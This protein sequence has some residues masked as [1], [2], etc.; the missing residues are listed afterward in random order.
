ML[1]ILEELPAGLLERDAN[2]VHEVLSGPTLIHLQGRRR[3]P[4]LV[5]VLL[6]GNEV[7]GWLAARELLRQ[8]AHKAL[9]RSLSLLIGNVTAARLATRRLDEQPDYNRVWG[10]G[11]TPEHAVARQVVAEM[12]E[13]RAFASVDVHNN[14]GFNPHYACVNRLAH[15][16]LHLATLYSRTVVYFTKPDTVQSLAMAQICPAVTLEC[17]QPGQPHG[18]EHVLE[19]LNACLH[20]TALPEHPV[21][22]HD[23]DLFHTVA[24]LKVPDH[25]SF[26]FRGDGTDI[27]FVSDLDHLNFR[28]LCAGTVLGWVRGDGQTSLEAWDEQGNEVGQRY[29]C[30]DEGRITT[31]IPIMPSMLTLD[32]RVIRQDCL[33]YIMERYPLPQSAAERDALEVR[34]AGSVSAE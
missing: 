31:A 32:I 27:C 12:A 4:L 20:L 29:F 2:Q 6:H 15:P 18:T 25:R 17:G 34:S 22:A 13:R 19:Y 28:E 1:T 24:V 16:F 7:T 26:G 30:V 5:T 23:I 33:G 10:A 14:T 3:E 21:A 8:Y 11:D 9:P